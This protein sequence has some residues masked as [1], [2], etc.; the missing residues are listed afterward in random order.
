MLFRS[1]V[2]LAYDMGQFDMALTGNGIPPMDGQ[3]VKGLVA[4]SDE[5]SGTSA[6]ELAALMAGNAYVNL[7]KTSE[8]QVQFDKAAS[9]DALIV[10]VGALQ[11][12]AAVSELQKNFSEAA[13][14][15]EEAAVKAK[16][17][18]LE[19]QSYVNAA[20]CYEEAKN[21]EKAIELYRMIAKKFEMSEA[22]ATAKAGLARLGT[23]ID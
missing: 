18:G 20:A 13:V 2:R 4:I 11:G 10:Q 8:A 3:P 21:N 12:L 7:G 6:G 1:R 16:E 17:T 23:T 22:A 14:K 19:E 15:Y 5:Y 9:S